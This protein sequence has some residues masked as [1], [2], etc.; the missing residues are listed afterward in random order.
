MCV[1]LKDS[2]IKNQR[3]IQ[4]CIDFFKDNANLLNHQKLLAFLYSHVCSLC[5]YIISLI[6]Y[7]TCSLVKTRSQINTY[8]VKHRM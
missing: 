6:L 3:V 2:D 7:C 1:C 5:L 4:L 8:F